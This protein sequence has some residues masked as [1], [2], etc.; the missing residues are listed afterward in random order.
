[1]MMVL[2]KTNYN[3]FLK[4]PLKVCFEVNVSSCNTNSKSGFLGCLIKGSRNLD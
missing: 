1:M 4:R 3:R 2:A